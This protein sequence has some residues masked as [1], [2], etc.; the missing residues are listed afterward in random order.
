[1]YQ[2]TGFGNYPELPKYYPAWTLSATSSTERR[3]NDYLNSLFLRKKYK[4]VFWPIITANQRDKWTVSTL[5]CM[6]HLDNLD[7]N[8]VSMFFFS[9]KQP[10]PKGRSKQ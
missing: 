4:R 1:M 9:V 8:D 7:K 6:H 2:F 3:C 5:F 10:C